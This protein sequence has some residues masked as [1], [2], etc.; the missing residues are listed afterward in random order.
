MRRDAERNRE[1]IL[2]AAREVYA[3]Q[4]VEAPL[5]VVARRAGVGNATV[6][7]RFPD[8]GALIEAVFHEQ[9]EATAV[10]GEEAR[11]SED[12]WQGLVEYLEYI[13][14]GLTRDRGTTDLMT[15]GIAGIPSLDAL[16]EHHYVTVSGLMSRAQRDGTMREDIVPE[17]L[18]FSLAALGRALPATAA[19]VSGAWRRHLALLFDGLRAPGPVTR[20]PA[21]PFSAEE[22]GAVLRELGS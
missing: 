16:A 10:R 4:G 8:R 19:V 20:L 11:A 1:L 3:E 17:D 7:R 12:A 18:L 13:F 15:T 6:Y 22:L 9:L 2:A 5:D 14:E 21:P